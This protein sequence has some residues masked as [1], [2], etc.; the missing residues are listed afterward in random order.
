MVVKNLS[1][2][3]FV[4]SL[5]YPLV[6]GVEPFVGAHVCVCGH[7]SHTPNVDGII[8]DKETQNKFRQVFLKFNEP[9]IRK[10]WTD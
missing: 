7:L 9:R 2:F 6:A 10:P 3:V 5:S 1:R 4:L 8:M